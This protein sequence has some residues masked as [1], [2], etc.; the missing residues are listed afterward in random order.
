M[1]DLAKNLQKIVLDAAKPVEPGMSIK[2]Q[3]NQACDNLGY[4][5][6]HWRVRE[7]WYGEADNWRAKAVFEMIDR[8]N[9]LV[10]KRTGPRSAPT[11]GPL[12]STYATE[13]R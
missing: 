13:N 3:I 8:H 9:R 6:G 4:K 11:D 10:S 2:A 1:Q 12:F 5:R 7:A